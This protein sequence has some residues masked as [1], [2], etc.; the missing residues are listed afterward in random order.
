MHIMTVTKMGNIN[1]TIYT[2]NVSEIKLHDRYN[3]NNGERIRVLTESL[4]LNR[5]PQGVRPDSHTVT[6]LMIKDKY[7][8]LYLNALVFRPEQV[9]TAIEVLGAINTSNSS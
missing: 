7:G 8:T 4:H 9:P 2:S 3:V 1:W 5:D 6:L